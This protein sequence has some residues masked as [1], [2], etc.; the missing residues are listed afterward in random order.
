MEPANL[1][2]VTT[3][4]TLMV[5]SEIKLRSFEYHASGSHIQDMVL[6][7]CESIMNSSLYCISLLHVQSKL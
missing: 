6:D 5:T 1:Q 7:G 4:L 3:F 2:L